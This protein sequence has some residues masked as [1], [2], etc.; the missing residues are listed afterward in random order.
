MWMRCARVCVKKEGR[1]TQNQHEFSLLYLHSSFVSFCIETY[2]LIL[3]EH[4]YEECAANAHTRNAA[5]YVYQN[6]WFWLNE[7]EM[8]WLNIT[9]LFFL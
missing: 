7:A 9:M 2:V 4:K 6:A 8:G 3:I 5:A 1:A